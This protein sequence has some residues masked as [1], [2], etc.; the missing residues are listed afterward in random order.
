[1]YMSENNLDT[2]MRQLREKVI[3]LSLE[4][5]SLRSIVHVLALVTAILAIPAVAFLL[6]I[7][8]TWIFG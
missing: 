7:K 2:E 8:I 6:G 4:V 5:Q 1:M 3:K